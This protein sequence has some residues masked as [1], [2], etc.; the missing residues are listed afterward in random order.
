[1]RKRLHLRL[2]LSTSGLWTASSL[3]EAIDAGT[4]GC[5]AIDEV[6]RRTL[7]ESIQA[8]AR[9]DPKERDENEEADLDQ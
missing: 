5:A 7:R 9:E 8:K 1:M 4:E 3:S 6:L 2:Q